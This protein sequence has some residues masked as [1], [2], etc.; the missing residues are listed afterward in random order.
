MAYSIGLR[1]VLLRVGFLPPF[2]GWK[3]RQDA[4]FPNTASFQQVLRVLVVFN[5]RPIGACFRFAL[6]RPQ[7]QGW[8]GCAANFFWPFFFFFFGAFGMPVTFSRA[9]IAER[10]NQETTAVPPTGHLPSQPH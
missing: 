1:S 4:L 10:L 8:Q 9:P 3:N 7:G 6:G 2:R 5:I